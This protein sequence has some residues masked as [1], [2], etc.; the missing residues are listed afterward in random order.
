M[1]SA[2][3]TRRTTDRARSRS[4]TFG[5][6]R[7]APRGFAC[8]QTRSKVGAQK[9]EQ[10]TPGTPMP[11]IDARSEGYVATICLDHFAKRNALSETL[12][13][14]FVAALDEFATQRA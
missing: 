8:S 4:E 9:A 10:E 1:C 13:D 14:E 2:R 12:V 6:R 5:P 7:G 11:L 3:A